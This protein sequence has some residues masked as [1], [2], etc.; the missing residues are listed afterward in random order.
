M[1]DLPAYTQL[2]SRR[3]QYASGML[4]S[5]N[6]PTPCERLPRKK[7]RAC[8]YRLL[9]SSWYPNPSTQVLGDLVF[10]YKDRS[11]WSFWITYIDLSGHT[12][13]IH[14]RVRAFP[15][16]WVESVKDDDPKEIARFLFLNSL[17][18]HSDSG[19]GE[20]AEVEIGIGWICRGFL[21][22][23]EIIAA[24]LSIFPEVIFLKDIRVEGGREVIVFSAFP[25]YR[26]AVAERLAN[27]KI[28]EDNTL[29]LK[30]WHLPDEG[31]L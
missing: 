31:N 4:N 12:D 23:H 21:D 28:V 30:P 2:M 10:P 18:Q 5:V 1:K 24:M 20:Q 19:P 6:L 14:R 27:V 3:G 29:N 7:L 16:G 8:D 26:E 17:S 13:F 25:E 15:T 22:T 11:Y 9:D